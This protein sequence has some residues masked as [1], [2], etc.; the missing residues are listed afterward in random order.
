MTTCTTSSFFRDIVRL[1]RQAFQENPT[2]PP[3]LPPG[4]KPPPRIKA[5]SLHLLNQELKLSRGTVYCSHGR[6]V[7]HLLGF[8][9]WKSAEFLFERRLLNNSRVDIYLLTLLLVRFSQ[10]LDWQ[11]WSLSLKL[12]RE[13]S[14]AKPSEASFYQKF[15]YQIS[16]SAQ[17]EDFGPLMNTMF[18]EMHK[19]QLSFSSKEYVDIITQLLRQDAVN[20]AMALLDRLPLILP[21]SL[22]DEALEVLIRKG[23][24]IDALKWH[25]LTFSRLREPV[26]IGTFNRLLKLL[27][28]KTPSKNL[29]SVYSLYQVLRTSPLIKFDSVTLSIVSHPLH[30]S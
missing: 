14:L 25:E 18:Q 7:E 8:N 30:I 4:T 12:L 21:V 13:A 26:S 5:C 27:T 9:Q 24:L 3:P 2:P 22:H 28:K 23:N 17:P 20:L 11:G 1:Y 16:S 29:D 19:D 15:I 10:K 6:L